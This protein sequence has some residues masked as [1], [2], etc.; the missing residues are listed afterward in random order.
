MAADAQRTESGSDNY[1]EAQMLHHGWLMYAWGLGTGIV[2][3][4]MGGLIFGWIA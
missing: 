4:V 2:G 1:T 3:T